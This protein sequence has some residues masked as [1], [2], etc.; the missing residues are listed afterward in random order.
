MVPGEYIKHEGT[1]SRVVI[2]GP[3]RLYDYSRVF[4]SSVEE[5]ALACSLYHPGKLENFKTH[6]DLDVDGRKDIRRLFLVFKTTIPDEV[7]RKKESKTALIKAAGIGRLA[8]K[9]DISLR[10]LTL[11]L[12]E[13]YGLLDYIKN[14]WLSDF[15]E[16][17]GEINNVQYSLAIDTK[18]RFWA[19]LYK[20][21]SL[22]LI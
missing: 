3:L 5:M 2:I 12:R 22:G 18:I 4:R 1:F 15:L 11:P 19:S 13:N 10:G 6:L 8:V 14:Y 21:H 20:S 16:G 9:N 7:F 17:Y